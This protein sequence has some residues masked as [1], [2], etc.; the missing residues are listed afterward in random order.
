MCTV[1][2]DSS[3]AR[4]AR[5]PMKA[6]LGMT[7]GITVPTT[8]L[9]STTWCLCVSSVGLLTRSRLRR[10]WQST[11][12]SR[13]SGTPSRSAATRYGSEGGE[14]RGL[15]TRKGT[16]VL[17][18]SST[19]LCLLC[20]T[21]S[22]RLKACLFVCVLTGVCWEHWQL[23]GTLQGTPTDHTCRRSSQKQLGVS[24]TDVLLMPAAVAADSES[25]M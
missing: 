3:L 5:T 14:D 13:S 6:C 24:S 25:S 15:H 21:S 11:S 4:V 9:P 12:S 19:C 1:K 7:I 18:G 22:N 8:Y 16:T 10:W 2:F 23:Q 20:T 17:S